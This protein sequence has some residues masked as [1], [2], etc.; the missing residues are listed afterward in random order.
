MSTWIKA[1]DAVPT[2]EV[3]YLVVI[4]E[5]VEIAVWVPSKSKW[6]WNGTEQT[7]IEDVTHWMPLPEVPSGN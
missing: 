7:H 2:T 6:W 3:F 4:D 1:N 5:C